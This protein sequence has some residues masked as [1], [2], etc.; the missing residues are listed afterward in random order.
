MKNHIETLQD[1]AAELAT[2]F[3]LLSE[4]KTQQVDVLDSIQWAIDRLSNQERIAAQRP[5]KGKL[6]HDREEF[7][8]WGWIRDEAGH[9]I[10]LAQ[11]P[12][13][14]DFHY[15]RREGI[16]PAQ[17]RV[18][19]LLQAFGYDTDDRTERAE[20]LLEL[21][22][23][24]AAAENMDWQQVVLNGGPP[25]FHL[26]EG[27]TRF[28]GRAHRW[29]GH[30]CLHA[31]VSFTDLLRIV[32]YNPPEAAQKAWEGVKPDAWL[33]NLRGTGEEKA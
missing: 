32:A 17:A 30:G 19:A 33:E 25:C 24:I 13:G 8:D 14:T 3:D 27:E 12:N 10:F 7:A 28:C 9:L 18:D 29:H 23:I 2:S 22:K 4:S 31:F 15:H 21:P 20:A 16:D 5:W 6:H 26:P 11:A 1:F